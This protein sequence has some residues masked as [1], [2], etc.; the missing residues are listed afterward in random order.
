MVSA[1]ASGGE[2]SVLSFLGLGERAAAERRVRLGVIG[3]NLPT[4]ADGKQDEDGKSQRW[5]N[6]R[7]RYLLDATHQRSHKSRLSLNALRGA[8]DRARRH[9]VNGFTI[10]DV[11]SMV[12]QSKSEVLRESKWRRARE[13]DMLTL[14]K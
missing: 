3:S 14:R 8:R 5:R 7:N 12:S 4:S 11:V 1:A 2:D 9:L 6:V 10:A 13:G